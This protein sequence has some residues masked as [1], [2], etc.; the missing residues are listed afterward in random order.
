MPRPWLD[1]STVVVGHDRLYN[2]SR[3][4]LPFAERMSPTLWVSWPAWVI[5]PALG[6]T[7]HTGIGQ[8]RRRVY[9]DVQEASSSLVLA[10]CWLDQGARA[11]NVCQHRADADKD[12]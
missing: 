10:S 11:G 6:S 12:E 4:W 9:E 2:V 3:A 8:Q 7:D 5:H 1:H